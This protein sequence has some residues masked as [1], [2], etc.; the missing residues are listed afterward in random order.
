MRR[1]LLC[2]LLP[3]WGCQGHD[4]LFPPGLLD[5][6]PFHAAR[7]LRLNT[8]TGVEMLEVD[9]LVALLWEADEFAQRLWTLQTPP[10]S[11]ATLSDPTAPRPTFVPDVEGEYVVGLTTSMGPA[12]VDT[13]TKRLLAAAYLGRASCS[14]CHGER[15]AAAAATSHGTTLERRAA[16]LFAIPGC[17]TC[18]VVGSNATLPVPAPGGFDDEAAQVGFDAQAY[19]FTDFATFAADFPTLADRGAVQ[20]ESCH[21]PGSLHMSDPRNTSISTDARLCGACHN[22]FAP[23]FKQW[24]L[25]VHAAA[26]PAGTNDNPSCARC[27]TARGFARSVAGLAPREQGAGEPGVTCAACHDPHSAAN[28]S[29]VRVFGDVT[30]GDG[31][32][33][34]AGR[35]AVC[36]TC[37]QSE[38]SDA[39]AYA[40]LGEPFPCAIQA[41]M[42]AGRGAVEYGQA[43]G[44]SF[45]GDPGF[46]PRNLTGNP[47]DPLFPEACVT[48]H[49][50][51]APVAGPFLDRLGGHTWRMRDG[52]TELAV[53]NCDRCHPGL[54]TFD[55]NLGRDFDGS[56]VAEGV[57]TEVR[58]LIEILHAALVAAD[59]QQGLSRP[60]GPGTPVTVAD[61]LSL[62]TAGLRQAA[63]NYNFIVRDASFGVHNT[64]YAVQLLQRTYEELAG[65]PFT[66]AFPLAYIP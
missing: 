65:A 58:G 55:R 2:F 46:K 12:V 9:V 40:T 48:C 13:V 8:G 23:R 38:V 1:F 29:E 14:V 51:P 27:H 18:H 17:L 54:T 50:A 26:P 33:F 3:L 62:T 43:F 6:A 35:A 49:M 42:V 63:Y 5:P 34:D 11:A 24:Q 19:V 60:G 20:C 7:E 4:E 22:T 21:G 39:A 64:V 32:T 15:A 36:V 59:P 57:Q 47:N 61:D 31:S 41:D 44:S 56:G 66:T 53:G 16:E 10:G 25:S 30:L 45:H 28:L 37:H 52:A